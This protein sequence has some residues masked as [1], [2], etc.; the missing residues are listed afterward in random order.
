MYSSSPTFFICNLITTSYNL[1]GG[2]GGEEDK[3][4]M[5]N[6]TLRHIHATIVAV[7]NQK[8]QGRFSG[9]PEKLY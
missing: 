8:I 4:Y 2:E 9:K 6:A 1:I 3:Q 5:C 7:E